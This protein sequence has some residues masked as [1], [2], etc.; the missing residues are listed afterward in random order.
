[1]SKYIT[2]ELIEERLKKRGLSS[3][4]GYGAEDEDADYKKLCKHYDFELIDE[5]HGRADYF[6]YTETTA[7][8]YEVW[9]T[10]DN[11]RGNINVS[12]DV[13]Y[14]DN[15]LSEVLQEQIRYGGV[16]IYVDDMDAYYVND[17]L[18]NMFENMIENIKNEIIVEL[19]DE[20]Y[21]YEDAEAVA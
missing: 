10:T 1:M 16:V 8:G 9:V 6:I 14:Y 4:D 17:A 11:D 19:E 5:W 12:E 13:H 7:D 18:E 21:E 2:D 15:D 20:G 3:Y